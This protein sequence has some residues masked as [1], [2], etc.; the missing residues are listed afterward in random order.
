MILFLFTFASRYITTQHVPKPYKT[1][2]P[3]L[4]FFPQFQM[5]FVSRFDTGDRKE[6][7]ELVDFLDAFWKKEQIDDLENYLLNELQFASIESPVRIWKHDSYHIAFLLFWEVFELDSFK[8]VSSVAREEIVALWERF[9]K[10]INVKSVLE[11]LPLKR[12]LLIMEDT[13]SLEVLSAAVNI[14]AWL[15]SEDDGEESSDFLDYTQFLGEVLKWYLTE[16]SAGE[17]VDSLFELLHECLDDALDNAIELLD[18]SIDEL[19]LVYNSAKMERCHEV[20]EIVLDREHEIPESLLLM[21][22][23][24][25]DVEEVSNKSGD[26][27]TL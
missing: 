17:C 16:N 23:C 8:E 5:S 2:T 12:F 26:L 4:L 13:G 1:K 10:V 15:I 3:V 18:K 6:I 11:F 20:F 19:P 9:I 14:L 25:A 22:V 7:D 27:K 24:M 21:V